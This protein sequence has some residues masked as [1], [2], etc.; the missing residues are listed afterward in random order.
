MPKKKTPPA[1]D[2][3]DIHALQKKAAAG[4]K[5][6]R[7][8]IEAMTPTEQASFAKMPKTQQTEL[9]AMSA[10]ARTKALADPGRPGGPM[11]AMAPGSAPK[12]GKQVSAVVPDEEKKKP[13]KET[14]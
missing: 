11:D 14:K 7:A 3:I 6:R 8:A 5:A 12:V 13:A 4:D 9:L 10:E 1:L 2:P